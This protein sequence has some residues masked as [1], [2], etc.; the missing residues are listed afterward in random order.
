[1]WATRVSRTGMRELPHA[2]LARPVWRAD[3]GRP[4]QMNTSLGEGFFGPLTIPATGARLE[5][6]AERDRR[7]AQR[8]RPLCLP[9]W[10]S[11][12][13]Y[14]LIKWRSLMLRLFGVV[15]LA[16]VCL[17]FGNPVKALPQIS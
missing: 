11:G 5:Q 7:T 12:P 8:H 13:W 10:G 16:G 15:A 2:F 3:R 1:M 9:E 17:L 4:P 6:G 14:E